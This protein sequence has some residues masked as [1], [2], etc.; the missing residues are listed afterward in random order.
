ML[1]FFPSSNYVVQ[2]IISL[3]IAEV[4]DC[5]LKMLQGHFIHLSCDKFASHVVEKLLNE[6]GKWNS[7]QIISEVLQDQYVP[8]LLVDQYGNFVIKSALNG[9]KVNTSK[10]I[11]LYL[12]LFV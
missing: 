4:T 5:M 9:S 12:L 3:R 1:L 11:Y 8:M 6:S 2:H 10:F 7:E